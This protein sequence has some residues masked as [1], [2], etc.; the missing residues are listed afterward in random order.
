[1]DGHSI[2]IGAQKALESLQ[3]DQEGK[4]LTQPII[5]SDN[6]SGYISKEFGGLLAHHDLTHHRIKPHCPEENGAMER[7]NR[8]IREAIEEHDLVG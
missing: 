3:M 5:R 4:V 8:T 6:G 1:M 2:S 7:C